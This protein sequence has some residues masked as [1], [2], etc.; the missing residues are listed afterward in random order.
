MAIKKWD[1]LQDLL[2]LQE[3]M[4]HM[5]EDALSRTV[6]PEGADSVTGGWRPPT[7]LF[8]EAER[9]ILRADLPGVSA[10]DVEIQVENGMLHLRGERKMEANLSREAFLRIER[11]YGKFVV[12]VA[13]PPSVDQQ[14][15]RARH[16][17]GVIEV[18]LPKKKA[19]TPSRI[20]ISS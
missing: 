15:I 10:T 14:A 11:P 6:G 5:F 16:R 3:K 2:G 20:E 7:D 17:N 19:E 13:L 4:N 12:Q 1:P 9:Y 18:L 8:E